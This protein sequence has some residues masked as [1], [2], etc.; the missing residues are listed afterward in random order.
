MVL[1]KWPFWSPHMNAIVSAANPTVEPKTIVLK[2]CTVTLDLVLR[3]GREMQFLSSTR[4]KP[5]ELMRVLIA[6][7]TYARLPLAM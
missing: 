6:Q 3:L 1:A 7:R 5:D 4:S 2:D